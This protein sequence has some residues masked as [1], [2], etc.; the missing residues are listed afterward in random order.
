MSAA[1]ESVLRLLSGAIDYAG[2]FPPATLSMSEAVRN[3]ATY[4]KG[5]DSW[6]LGRFI[7]SVAH[8]DAF[9]A[10]RKGIAAAGKW[11]LSAL[12]GTD[13]RQEVARVIEFNQRHQDAVTIDTIEL[14]SA[15][16]L[17][18]GSEGTDTIATVCRQFAVYVEIPTEV[19]SFDQENLLKT[20]A[21]AGARA[22]IRTGGLTPDAFPSP[23][24]LARFLVHCAV[25]SLRFKATAGL[26]HVTRGSYS[27]T[28]DREGPT[29][30]THGFVNLFLAAAFAQAGWVEGRLAEV[31]EE[32]ES[33]A[34]RFG[35]NGVSW[36]ENFLTL[37]ALQRVRS[38]FLVSFGSCDFEG[39]ITELKQLVRVS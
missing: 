17:K 4:L 7:L 24:T 39:P 22:K 23:E 27:L 11:R 13:I 38:E 30:L 5:A 12:L 14:K 2:L 35:P 28:G 33:A 15:I 36:R 25:A 8:L 9:A 6:A 16:A 19:T 26:H 20:M 31:L 3:Y 10:A 18:D 37:E 34:F 21:L 1:N 32:T 29:A